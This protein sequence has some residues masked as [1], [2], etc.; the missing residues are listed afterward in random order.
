MHTLD[1]LAG[2]EAV[3]AHQAFHNHW[4]WGQ[5]PSPL[6]PT[7]MLGSIAFV[8]CVVFMRLMLHSIDKI[9]TP[10]FSLIPLGILSIYIYTAA[11]KI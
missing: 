4:V 1:N 10:F 9:K 2:D 6:L 11:N 7:P 3:V 5:A 8:T